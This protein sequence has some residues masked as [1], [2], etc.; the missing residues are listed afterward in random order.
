MDGVW[1]AQYGLGLASDLSP[2]PLKADGAVANRLSHDSIRLTCKVEFS[3]AWSIV[4]DLLHLP[5]EPASGRSMN[6]PFY[7]VRSIKRFAAEPALDDRGRP[8]SAQRYPSS[9]IAAPR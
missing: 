7:T 3:T 1:T 2:H 5:G 9:V 8:Q 4:T 6:V